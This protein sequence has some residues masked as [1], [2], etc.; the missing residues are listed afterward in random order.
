MLTVHPHTA[1]VVFNILRDTAEWRSWFWIPGVCQGNLGRYFSRDSRLRLYFFLFPFSFDSCREAYLSVCC[2]SQQHPD[3]H[4][5]SYTRS[6][7]GA[8]EYKCSPLLKSL[9]RESGGGEASLRVPGPDSPSRWAIYAAVSVGCRC[10]DTAHGAA[11][12]TTQGTQFN[13]LNINLFPK[14]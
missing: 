1:G 4:S 2:V 10:K 5:H 3:S 13:T 14:F 7:L 9:S 6:H 8:A 11:R 12:Y